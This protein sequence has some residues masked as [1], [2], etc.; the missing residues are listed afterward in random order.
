MLLM[1]DSTT[2][3]YAQSLRLLDLSRTGLTVSYANWKLEWQFFSRRMAE[4]SLQRLGQELRKSR[5]TVL[6]ANL[7]PL[8]LI[9]GLKTSEWK[10]YVD[11][12]VAMLKSNALEFLERKIFLGPA[13]IH[14][15]TNDMT[16]PRMR[17]WME[18]ALQQLEPLGFELLDGWTVTQ[19]RPESTWDGVHYSAE[20]GKA[21]M[22]HIRRR[23]PV[24]KW[25][26]GVSIMLATILISM[27]C[28]GNATT[29]R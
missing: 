4:E 2:R 7:G 15:A 11:Q 1:G 20:R 6:V 29:T 17:L 19:S 9:G 3:E 14:Y 10:Y 21:Q 27:L 8:H 25:N 16:A 26:G 5:P 23:R 24:F 28:E 18:Y 13:A 12:W 22:K